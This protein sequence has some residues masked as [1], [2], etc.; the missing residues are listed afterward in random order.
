VNAVL[1][2]GEATSLEPA[3]SDIPYRLLDGI[4]IENHL[5]WLD[6]LY[7]GDLADLA[8]QVMGT[9]MVPSNSVRA[10]VNVN[11]LDGPGGRYELHVDSNPLTGLLFV[12]A[13]DDGS[14]GQL[15]FRLEAG[16]LLVNP[17][18]GTFITF[19]ARRIPHAVTPLRTAS[20][21]ISVP[22]NFYEV[23]GE[24][25]GSRSAL[26]DY[27]YGSEPRAEGGASGEI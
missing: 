10:G 8:S 23:E 11:V 25:T 19:D 1:Y 3:G 22:M 7:R 2:G 6:A 27:L 20:T 17:K 4:G 9:A 24:A 5:P 16:D 14:G 15:Q 13:H 21:R 26:D 18:P 12:T